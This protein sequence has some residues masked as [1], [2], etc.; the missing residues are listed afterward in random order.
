MATFAGIRNG[1]AVYE[2]RAHAGAKCNVDEKLRPAAEAAARR[3]GVPPGLYV[4]LITQESCWNP[5][6]ISPKG[7]IGLAQLMPGTAADLGVNPHQ[8]EENLDGG[9]RYLKRQF[10]KFGSWRLA[11]AAYNAGPG[12]VSK[13]AGIPPYAETQ[14]YVS[15]ILANVERF[16]SALK[17]S[18][19]IPDGES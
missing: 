6:A 16:D 19:I 3:H 9:G 10:L 11:L 18:K 1:R 15:V 17:T 7:A 8:I 14:E 12:A 13:Y 2:C 4:A 5:K